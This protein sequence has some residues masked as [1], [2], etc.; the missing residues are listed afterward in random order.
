MQRAYQTQPQND[1]TYF[2]GI[3]VE[4]TPHHG[5]VTLF[6]VGC[7]PAEEILRQAASA[8]AQHIYLGANKSFRPHNSWKEVTAHLLDAG[9]CVTLD[10]PVWQHYNVCCVMGDLMSHPRLTPMISVEIPHVGDVNPNTTVK[11]DDVDFNSTNPGVWC[12]PL[13]SFLIPQHFTPWE[14]YEQDQVIS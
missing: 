13:R 12:H 2:T 11:I 5:D 9:L 14:A 3:E 6:V 10:Y 8:S 4:H 1:V 7:Q